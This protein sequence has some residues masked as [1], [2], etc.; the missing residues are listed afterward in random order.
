VELTIS[1]ISIVLALFTL[2]TSGFFWFFTYRQSSKIAQKSLNRDFFEKIYFNFIINELPE[3]IKLLEYQIG[4]IEAIAEEA[5]LL[6]LKMIDASYFYKY[7]DSNFYNKVSTILIK[8]DE[9]LVM[10]PEY[11][12]KPEILKRKNNEIIKLNVDLYTELKLYYSNI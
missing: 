8:F 6:I 10:I 7:F 4:D 11:K 2:I 3:K 5:D 9:I 12:E 1:K